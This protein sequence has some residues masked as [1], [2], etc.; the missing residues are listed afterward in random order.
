MDE[1]IAWGFRG[2]R[3]APRAKRRKPAAA[4][5]TSPRFTRLMYSPTPLMFL[6]ATEHRAP[7][8]R[9]KTALTD[10]CSAMKDNEYEAKAYGN[11]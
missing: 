4:V 7:G 3:A 5:A 2:G 1:T 11:Q 10:C 9:L 6:R 8:N